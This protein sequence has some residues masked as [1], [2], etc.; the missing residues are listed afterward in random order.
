MK[1]GSIRRSN[2][3]AAIHQ[4]FD[5]EDGECYRQAFGNNSP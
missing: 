3:K 1:E 5:L 2:V 4:E